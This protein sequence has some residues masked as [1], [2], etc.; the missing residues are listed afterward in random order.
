MSQDLAYL[1]DSSPPSAGDSC[2]P[3]FDP[4]AL[5][6]L[7]ITKEAYVPSKYHDP[8]PANQVR[9]EFEDIEGLLPDQ[10]AYVAISAPGVIVRRATNVHFKVRTGGSA[11][12]PPCT[13]N[14]HPDPPVEL[15]GP[16]VNCSFDLEPGTIYDPDD[17]PCLPGDS[18]A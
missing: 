12:L 4:D 18:E 15:Y 17:S 2:A 7:S 3:D 10:R 8:D 11:P 16:F 6:D 9:N 13:T 14:P 5:P 1:E